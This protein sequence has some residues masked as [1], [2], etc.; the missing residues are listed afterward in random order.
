MHSGY[1]L[2]QYVALSPTHASLE[3]LPTVLPCQPCQVGR[4]MS[5]TLSADVV[6][7]ASAVGCGSATVWHKKPGEGAVAM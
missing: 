7:V 4:N 1:E 2:T 3:L 6:M 5:K